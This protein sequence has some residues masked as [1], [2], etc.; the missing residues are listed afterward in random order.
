MYASHASIID[1]LTVSR[2][3]DAAGV[4]AS[5]VRTMKARD[6]IPP[7]Y[8]QSVVAAAVAAGVEGVSFEVLAR[9]AADKRSQR[10]TGEPS[11]GEAAA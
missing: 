5:H 3:A 4:D 1:E 6:S 11:R 2:V 8:W 9:L 10:A 7:A